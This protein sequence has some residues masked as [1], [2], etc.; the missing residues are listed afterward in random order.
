MAKQW[1]FYAPVAYNEGTCAYSSA[2]DVSN[3]HRPLVTRLDDGFGDNGD[4]G[5]RCTQL[6]ACDRLHSATH[7]QLSERCLLHAPI[8][9]VA[10]KPNSTIPGRSPASSTARLRRRRSAK[11]GGYVKGAALWAVVLQ[12]VVGR[13]RYAAERR[14]RLLPSRPMKRRLPGAGNSV[15]VFGTA[16]H[17]STREVPLHRVM[18]TSKNALF[19]RLRRQLRAPILMYH[20]YTAVL[21][22]V[23]PCIHETMTIFS[24]PLISKA[25]ARPE[26]QG[27]RPEHH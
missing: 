2:N 21:R 23:L 25:P 8:L 4:G 9:G 3:R 22:A 24:G 19:P 27:P 18:G 26:T 20:L 7:V 6:L 12:P 5:R 17:A 14:Y 11:R 16:H 15:C 10:P 1:G 13:S